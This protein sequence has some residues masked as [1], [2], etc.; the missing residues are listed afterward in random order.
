M[1][2]TF[3][4][5]GPTR[6]GRVVLPVLL[7]LLAA[8]AVSGARD[9]WYDR[10]EQA[11]RAIENGRPKRAIELLGAALQRKSRSGYFRTYG[12]NYLRYA[13]Q[14]WLGVAYHDLDDCGRALASFARSEEAAE[15]ADEPELAARLRAL[16]M[17]CELRLAPRP[18]R[19]V[20]ESGASV[21]P[22]VPKGEP[23]R[24]ATGSR[25]EPDPVRLEQGLRAFLDG[26][27]TAAV[28]A[29]D[30]LVRQAPESATSH[31]LLGTAL[32]GQWSAGGEREVELFE[33]SRDELSRAA[34][35]DPRVVP[36]PALCSPRV[37][38]LYRSLR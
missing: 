28:R 1:R 2:S 32:H 10:Y 9:E 20:A 22:T 34:Q 11:V 21:P 14:F 37:V 30:E 38:A 16:R 26:D 5:S 8:T 29:F 4:R 24:S 31:L 7:G 3:H 23:G 13:P 6:F 19:R 36:D 35:L 33:R 15:T 17:A 27:L 18:E 12:N 25:H